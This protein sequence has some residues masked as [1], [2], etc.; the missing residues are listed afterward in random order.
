MRFKLLPF[1]QPKL[2][3]LNSTNTP[4]RAVLRPILLIGVY[5]GFWN[6]LLPGPTA[7]VRTDLLVQDRFEPFGDCA[8]RG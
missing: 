4:V 5:R 1:P 2:L 3:F 8:Q 7:F 6:L